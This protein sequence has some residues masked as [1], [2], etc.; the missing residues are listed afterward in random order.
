MPHTVL[1]NE[2]I[3]TI[4]GEHKK[5]IFQNHKNRNEKI[6]TPIKFQFIPNALTTRKSVAV[7]FK[8]VKTE[9]TFKKLVETT[10]F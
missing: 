10:N 2:K 1:K 4:K 3:C 6:S 9:E 7:Y 8:D 5:D